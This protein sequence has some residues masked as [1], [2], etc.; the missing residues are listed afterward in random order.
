[1]TNWLGRGIQNEGLEFGLL[2][3]MV[4]PCGIVLPGGLHS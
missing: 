1:M 3:V 4:K 2:A